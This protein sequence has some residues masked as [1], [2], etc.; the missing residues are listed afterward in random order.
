[1]YH[2]HSLLSTTSDLGFLD[3]GQKTA[4]ACT[5]AVLPMKFTMALA[6]ATEILK[7]D[8]DAVHM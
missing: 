8:F 6:V 3:W 5:D 7:N 4:G 2:H 1:M